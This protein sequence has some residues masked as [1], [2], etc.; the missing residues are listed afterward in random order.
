MLLCHS[1]VFGDNL[2]DTVVMVFD[3]A[4]ANHAV[5]HYGIDY[6]EIDGRIDFPS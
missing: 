3:K 6:F 2:V 5:R 1:A 4:S